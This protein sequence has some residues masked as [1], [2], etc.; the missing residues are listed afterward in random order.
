[1]QI[2]PISSLQLNI[3]LSSVDPVELKPMKHS[4]IISPLLSGV[5][6]VK[7]LMFV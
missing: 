1:M 2:L 7:L 4:Y 5:L 3:R 6:G